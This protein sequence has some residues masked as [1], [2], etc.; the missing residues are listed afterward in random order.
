M[1]PSLPGQP[2]LEHLRKQA[3]ALLADAEA[4]LPRALERL[5]RVPRLSALAPEAIAERAQLADAQH[6]IAI[7][8]GA[9]SWPKL[10]AIVEAGLPLAE[11]AEH[12]LRDV[13]EEHHD[14]AN[15]WI[16]NMP[17]L[18]AF[19]VFTASAAGDAATVS[20]LL[21]ADATLALAM[22]A[23]AAWSAVLYVAASPLPPDSPSLALIARALLEAGGDANSAYPGVGEGPPQS[24]LYRACIRGHVCVARALLEHGARTDDGES[25]G[26]AAEYAQFACLQAMADHGADFSSRQQPYDNTPLYFLAGYA[27]G[28]PATER[29]QAGMRWLLEHGAD[30]NVTSYA[31]RETP[32]HQVAR[33]GGGLAI[34]H[35]LLAHGANADAPRADG[36]TPY[37]IAYRRGDMALC[38]LLRAHGATS[39][40]SRV[41]EFLNAAL[42]GNEVAARAILAAEPDLISRFDAED[43]ATLPQLMAEKKPIDFARLVA[44]G[45]D[46]GWEG[47]WGGTPLHHAAWRGNVEMVRE[48]VRIG[49]PRDVRDRTYGS[50]PLA[51]AVHGS[52]FCRSADDEYLAIAQLLLEAG[53]SRAATINQWGEPPENLGSKRLS[54]FIQR[55][56]RQHPEQ[57]EG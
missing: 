23:D 32:L 46:L 36:R 30:P 52:R 13:R 39:K 28:N 22:H 26:H 25:I 55:W 44:L 2:D 5:R 27:A 17:A 35:A 50:S 15:R 48:L 19:N 1:S 54:A 43:H 49:A 47:A 34:A 7:E 45:F 14:V 51:W 24:A 9:E 11:Q 40:P 21:A 3:K 16:A 18:A 33:Q 10:K 29:A 12:F 8:H 31:R 4:A 56:Y 6:A 37:V 41:D 38:E 53:S 20:R 57:L 42:S